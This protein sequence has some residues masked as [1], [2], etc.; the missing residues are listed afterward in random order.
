MSGLDG[1]KL[2]NALATFSRVLRG[3]LALVGG[4]MTGSIA[5]SGNKVT[6]LGPA[7][8][9]GDAVRYEQYVLL[10]TLPHGFTS[11]RIPVVTGWASF[12]AG[13]VPEL[14]NTVAGAV[15]VGSANAGDSGGS[16]ATPARPWTDRMVPIWSMKATTAGSGRGA[17]CY[18]GILGYV[19]VY[20][21]TAAT[22]TSYQVYSVTG[23][24][25]YV[26]LGSVVF[27]FGPP[28]VTT[29]VCPSG[30]GAVNHVFKVGDG[31]GAA[32]ENTMLTLPI[33]STHRLRTTGVSGK[34][35]YTRE[36]LT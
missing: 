5:M 26:A 23:A 35:Y 14:C 36:S 29:V 7:M 1:G 18:D 15:I 9:D 30:A 28:P 6:G 10:R 33:D 22:E 3:Y 20:A 8:V 12:N 13:S 21:P 11:E 24:G 34:Q 4:T 27:V 31:S 16:V 17:G 25:A 32:Y 19:I 2:G